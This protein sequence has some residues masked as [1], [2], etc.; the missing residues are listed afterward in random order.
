MYTLSGCI[1]G[2]WQAILFSPNGSLYIQFTVYFS[3]FFPSTCHLT[4]KSNSLYVQFSNTH[5]HA[6]TC[7][8]RIYTRLCIKTSF[9]HLAKQTATLLHLHNLVAGKS[10]S[11][12]KRINGVGQVRGTHRSPIKGVW[13]CYYRVYKR[14][15]PVWSQSCSILKVNF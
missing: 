13:L 2:N 11:T 14:S 5:T 9:E 7:I 10:Q 4:S 1:L 6:F 12:V 3:L 8:L 15:V